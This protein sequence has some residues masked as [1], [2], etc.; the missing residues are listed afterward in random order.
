[1]RDEVKAAIVTVVLII[2]VVVVFTLVLSKPQNVVPLY[3]V[4]VFAFFGF[5]ASLQGLKVWTIGVVVITIALGI[6]YALT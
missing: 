2:A 3:L 4:P 1:M 5:V 6:L